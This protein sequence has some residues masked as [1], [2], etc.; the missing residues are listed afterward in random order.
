MP[1]AVAIIGIGC[2]Y[3]DANSPNE[4]WENI[5]TKRR[6]FRRMPEERFPLES[7]FSTDRNEPDKTYSPYAALIHGFEFDRVRYRIAGSTFRATDI[8]QWLA[9]Q[10]AEDALRDAGYEN[11]STMPRDT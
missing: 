3:P 4:F 11:P 7:Y 1:N 5:L 9:L 8:T 6:A 10:V 2:R